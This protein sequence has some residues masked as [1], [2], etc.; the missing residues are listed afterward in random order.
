MKNFSATTN[1]KA[2][3][4][5]IWKI[6]TDAPNYPTWDPYAIRIE[7]TIADGQSITAYTKLSPDRAFPVKVTDF[8]PNQR[9]SWVGGLPL[10][11]F[12]GVR[13]F[14]L[15]PKGD[16]TTD[17]TV[18][19]E[20]TGPLLVVMGRSLPDMTKPF[21]EFVRGLKARAEARA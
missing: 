4:D 6:L 2:S 17:F 21:Q 5:V 15:T 7:G 13:S 12:K 9:M 10:G 20:F 1:I 19:E 14:V 8:V 18:R 3:P 16:G 11:L